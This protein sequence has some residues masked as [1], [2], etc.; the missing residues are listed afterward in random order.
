MR[1]S[2]LCHFLRGSLKREGRCGG[3]IAC[4]DALMFRM[5]GMPRAQG[6]AGA[7]EH[8]HVSLILDILSQK[9]LAGNPPTPASASA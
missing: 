6:C 2:G 9:V 4:Q 5:N 7:A 3:G 1:G 8:I